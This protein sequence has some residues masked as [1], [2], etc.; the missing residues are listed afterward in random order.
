MINTN[1]KVSIITSVYNGAA[2]IEQTIQSVLN[3]TYRNIEYIV[4]DGKS[5]DGTQQVIEKYKDKIA[6]YVSEKDCGLY[7]AMNKGIEKATGDIVGIINSDD[8]YADDAVQVVVDCFKQNDLD[9]VYGKID[10]I[11]SDGI[12]KVCKI[13]PLE[14]MWYQMTIP[15]PSTFIRRSVY[16]KFGE[17]DT[18][19]K[20][21]ADYE[22]LLR[23]YTNHIRI[24]FVD[25]VIA[26]FRIGG[27]STVKRY[28][29]MNE[30]YTISMSYIG[31]CPYKDK[32]LPKIKETYE[33]SCFEEKLHKKEKFFYELL[34]KYFNSKIGDIIIFGTG[35]W[36][37]R[38][39]KA[40]SKADVH[41]IAFSDNDSVKWGTRFCGIDVIPPDKLKNMDV[42][43]LIA[44]KEHGDEIQEQFK[45]MENH[46]LKFVAINELKETYGV[47]NSDNFQANAGDI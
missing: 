31:K 23:F 10:S 30:G 24:K 22:L 42:Y 20:L 44:V 16:S 38:I 29:L 18:R 6:Y 41:I 37:E 11:S 5:T 1:Y 2:T 46:K 32:M 4:I 40:L 25:K 9:L 45:G 47:L 27:F 36:G 26:H 28:D 43:V 13:S 34:C 12:E 3:Q 35:T 21:A 8:W 33:W 17:F 19:Y 15:H 14:N 7:Y 39:Y